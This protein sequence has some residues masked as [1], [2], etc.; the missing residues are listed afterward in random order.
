MDTEAKIQRHLASAETFTIGRSAKKYRKVLK[1][2]LCHDGT[3]LS[4][5]ASDTHYCMPRDNDGPWCA[6]EVGFPSRKLDG[7]M[8]WAETPDA[9][10]E[11]V[12]GY[13]PMAVLVKVIDECG[14]LV[15]PERLSLK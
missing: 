14:G 6:V 4:I 11:T 2:V 3:T 7:L 5:Q 8:E 10:T 12:Y 1:R 9:P 15:G 13:V